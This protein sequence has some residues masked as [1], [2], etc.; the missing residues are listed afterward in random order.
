MPDYPDA[1]FFTVAPDWVCKV[2]SPS[3]RSLDL[4]GKREIYTSGRRSEPIVMAPTVAPA[5]E[6]GPSLGSRGNFSGRAC[7]PP[8][9]ASSRAMDGP[10]LSASLRPG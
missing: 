10:R 6:P 8:A 1:P 9:T 5:P 4:G 3:A 2:L 7:S